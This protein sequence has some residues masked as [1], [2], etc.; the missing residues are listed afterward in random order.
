[1][2]SNINDEYRKM[3]NN[4]DANM[5]NQEDLEYAKNQ[6]YQL[7]MLFIDEM[8][9]MSEKYED[10]INALAQNQKELEEKIQKVQKVVNSIEKDI[11]DEELD[12]NE[13]FE[14]EIVCP[15]CNNEFVAEV[16]ELKD[17]V[18][19]PECRNMIELD[20]EGSMEDEGGCSGNCS[21]CH[22]CDDDTDD[23]D[24]EDDDM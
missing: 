15:Y 20:W 13:T 23:E 8:Q 1:M 4:M 14:F 11:Y 9:A 12:S 5:S 22:S 3:L 18:Q 10:R 21:H 24:N 19:C 17:E 7:S 2:K 16:D 6:M